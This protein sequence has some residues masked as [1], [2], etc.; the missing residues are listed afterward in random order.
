[1]KKCRVCGQNKS[2]DD[3][4]KHP[5]AKDGRDSKCKECA[6]AAVKAN[7]D[8]KA[9]YYKQY[10]AWRF[11]ND[12][13]VRDRHRRYQST[14][15]GREAMLRARELWKNANPE[16][17]AAHVILG[18]AVKYGRIEKPKCCSKCGEFYPSRK[19]HAHHHDYTK[20]LDVVW[21]C[22]YCHVDEHKDN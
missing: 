8:K 20:P 15:D 2:L 1:M 3:Y 12:P 14:S 9:E 4:Y 21:M 7:R 6:K 11:Q 16:K 18:N 17:R 19:I 10:D 13:R 5:K 22:L